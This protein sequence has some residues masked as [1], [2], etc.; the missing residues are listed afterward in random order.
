MVPCRITTWASKV[1][2]LLSE[3]MV[4]TAIGREPCLSWGVGQVEDSF[5]IMNTDL[6][7]GQHWTWHQHVDI[8]ANTQGHEHFRGKK[9]WLMFQR[10]H[11]LERGEVAPFVLLHVDSVQLSRYSFLKPLGDWK[12]ACEPLRRVSFTSQA[13][14]PWRTPNVWT[15]EASP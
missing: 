1:C 15:G 9:K 13:R 6:M 14:W 7:Q 12:D 5:S 10:K 8:L 3:V 4:S 2:P 11:R